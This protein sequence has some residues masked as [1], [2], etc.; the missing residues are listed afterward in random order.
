[1]PEKKYKQI[2]YIDKKCYSWKLNFRYKLLVFLK[3]ASIYLKKKNCKIATNFPQ[4]LSAKFC[5]FWFSNKNI[6]PINTQ[7][8]L[9]SE[10]LSTCPVFRDFSVFFLCLQLKV[11]TLHGLTIPAAHTV[12]TQ[13]HAVSAFCSAICKCCPCPLDPRELNLSTPTPWKPASPSASWVEEEWR[14]RWKNIKKKEEKKQIKK[15]NDSNR[16]GVVEQDE[17]QFRVVGKE[18]GKKLKLT[19]LKALVL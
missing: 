7:T 15:K 6:I 9:N 5:I 3:V 12:L 4:R 14:H 10:I 17:K 13:G 2:K 18:R 1:M 11:V 8:W 19:R 16:D